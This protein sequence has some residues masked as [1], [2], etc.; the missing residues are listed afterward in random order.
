[1]VDL[2]SANRRALQ[3]LFVKENE[4]HRRQASQTAAEILGREMWNVVTKEVDVRMGIEVTLSNTRGTNY[5][6]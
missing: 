5:S 4:I 6:L 1:M 3:R 2:E